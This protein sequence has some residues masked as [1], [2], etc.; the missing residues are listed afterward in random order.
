MA[1]EMKTLTI[2]GVTYAPVDTTARTAAG[3]VFSDGETFQ[4]KYDNG[5]L[6]GSDGAAGQNGKSA[7]QAAQEAGYTGTEA[8]FNTQLAAVDQGILVAATSTDGVNY[9]ATVPGISALTIGQ[10][11]TLVPNMTSTSTA[12]KLDLNGLGAKQM[13]LA[14]A[15]YTSST[16]APANAGFFAANRP[17][18]LTYNGTFWVTN[19]VRPYASDLYGTV[20]VANGGVPSATADNEGQFLR[21]VS[22]APAWA[23]IPN[24]EEASF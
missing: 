13:R 2:D 8:E 12:A 9:T 22:G 21:V 16:M 5:S 20:P 19:I 6:K 3:T 7:Y 24:A 10:T 11:L 4:Q 1:T 15:S 17:V 18:Q 23:T 14:L